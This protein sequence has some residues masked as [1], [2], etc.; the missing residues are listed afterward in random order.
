[1]PR[2]RVITTRIRTNE[3]YSTTMGADWHVQELHDD[4]IVS[5]IE[6]LVTICFPERLIEAKRN[7]IAVS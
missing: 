1:M 5:L 6:G 7:Q 2:P 4:I 3:D